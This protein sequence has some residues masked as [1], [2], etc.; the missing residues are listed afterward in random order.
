MLSRY[1]NAAFGSAGL[2][3]LL[4][5]GYVSVKVLLWIISKIGSRKVSQS[6]KKLATPRV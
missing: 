4:L 2:G 1:P 3:G 5:I 6:E